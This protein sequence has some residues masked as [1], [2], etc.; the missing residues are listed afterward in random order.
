M[1]FSLLSH[2]AGSGTTSAINTTG[3]DLIVLALSGNPG[4][5][6]PT[7][8]QSNTWTGLGSF[9]SDF[10]SAVQIWYCASPF[11][12]A[13]HTFTDSDSQSSICAAAFS[14][15]NTIPIDTSTG[16]H[17][18]PVPNSTCP[19]ITP[20]QNNSLIITIGGTGWT[21]TT[22]I[23][24][25]FTVTDFVDL[26]SVFSIEMAYLIQG[27]AAAVNP[28]FSP[29]SFDG[30]GQSGLAIAVFKPAAAP[31]GRLSRLTLLGVG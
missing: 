6:T 20:G 4:T 2:G 26:G 30:F 29:S 8:S 21:N 19:S 23:D 25:G 17:N 5:G 14:G 3:A 22:T 7:D 31:A 10:N 13:S 11:T 12:S 28:T 15:S 27:T 1:S 18:L 24:Q 16:T 9:A